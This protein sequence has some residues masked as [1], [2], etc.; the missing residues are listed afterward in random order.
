MTASGTSPSRSTDTDTDPQGRP[1][2]RRGLK[3]LGTLFITL[4]AT[5]PASSVF[6]I[7]PGVVSQAGT[8][9]FW[10]LAVAGVVGVFMALVYAELSSAFPLSGGEYAI[11][12][13]ALGKLPGFVVLGLILVTQLLIVAVIAL[14]VGTYL[15]VLFP[16]LDVAVTAAVTTL[17][18]TAL[19]VFDIKLNA[20]VTGIFLAIE[21]VAL[22]VVSALGFLHPKRSL[23][24]LIAHPV[25]AAAS[26]STVTAVGVGTIGAA[27]AVAIFAYNGYGSAVY[28]GEETTDAPRNIS[29]TILWALGITVF[30]EL[31][32]TTAVLI[33]APNLPSLFSAGN[34]MKYFITATSNSTVN[35]AISLAVVVA[36]FNA[37]LAIILVT[38]RMVFSTG[39][40]AAWPGPA[41]R[42]LAAVHPRFGSPW[43]ATILTGVV[44]AGFCFADDTFLLVVTSTTIIAVYAALALSSIAGRRN[45]STAHAAYR[46]PAWPLAP[47]LA[48]GAIGYV[49]YENFQDP[50]VG[51]P[52]LWTTIGIAV[53]SAAYYLI[54]VRRRGAWELQGAEDA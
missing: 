1:R 54:V 34:M 23:G 42:A 8:G 6:I 3:M 47:V 45:G 5:T 46:M 37:V 7:S 29:R 39:R 44:S 30:A 16:H 9:A 14:G 35:D 52:S 53:V 51:R 41:S 15:E 4:S 25:A 20:W 17:L 43:I 36:I 24:D 22:I 19:A 38:A 10:A 2:L 48:L 32:P 31:I 11:T 40:D 26:G 18:A 28:F 27:T 49:V 50:K 13:R 12:A 21:M 33:G